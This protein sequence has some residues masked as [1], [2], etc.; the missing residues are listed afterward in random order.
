[1]WL[2]VANYAGIKGIL[3]LEE[4]IYTNIVNRENDDGDEVIVST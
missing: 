1:M 3:P 2:D 4:E